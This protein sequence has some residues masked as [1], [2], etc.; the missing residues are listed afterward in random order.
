VAVL[1]VATIQLRREPLVHRLH[2]HAE[3]RL[4]REN[5]GLSLFSGVSGGGPAPG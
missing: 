5:E 1:Q 2:P 4:G 3:V